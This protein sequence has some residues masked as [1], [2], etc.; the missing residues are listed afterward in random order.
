M[1]TIRQHADPPE[2]YFLKVVVPF[3]KQTYLAGGDKAHRLLVGF[4]KS[5]WGAFSLLLRYP[6]RFGKAAAWDA[7]LMIDVPLWKNLENFRKY[8][9]SRLAKRH[10]GYLERNRDKSFW[11]MVSTTVINSNFI[12]F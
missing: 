8:Q 6:D 10:T 3:V 11:G 12:R 4:S 5:G 1:L 9:I 7:P 2:T